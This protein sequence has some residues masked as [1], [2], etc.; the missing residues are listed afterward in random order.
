MNDR[1]GRWGR[2]LR[3]KRS[4]FRKGMGIRRGAACLALLLLLTA[5]TGCGSTRVVFTTGLGENEVFRIEEA[6]CT[7]PEIMVYLS[8]TQN[9]YEAV[10]G[11]EVWEISHNGVTLEEN[12]KEMVLAR[13]ARVKTMYLL[14][15]SKGVELDSTEREMAAQAAEEYYGSLSGSDVQRLGA[16]EDLIL[17]MYEEY[18]LANKVYQ[19]IL[20]DVNP[21]I[22]DDEARTITVQQI[23]I[24]TYTLDGTG[25][26]VAYTEELKDTAYKKAREIRELAVSEGQDFLELAS[27]SS[28]DP[29]ITCSFGKGE[30]D[31]AV[32]EAAFSL[33]TG[34]VSQVVESE[35][36]FYIIKC[37]NTFD[38]E[39]T[40]ANKLEIV[41]ERR[42]EV[43][44]QEYD[45]FVEGLSRSMNEKLWQQVGIFRNEKVGNAEFFQ[46]YEK[47]FS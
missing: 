34:E 35:D 27:R 8:N 30:M 41:E 11:P 4:K 12:V 1:S 46:M 37:I 13:I 14:A 47:Y 5:V 6:V 25:S 16:D 18:A 43:F 3:D 26:R 44:G 29:V 32:E 28:D 38:R 17:Q 7:L 31:P 20:K 36:G 45:A 22:S 42:R 21:E 23:M 39:Q 40:D 9:Q 2:G 15:E 33:E 19:L 24:R 10:Y